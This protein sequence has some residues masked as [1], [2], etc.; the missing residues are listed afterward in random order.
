MGGQGEPSPPISLLCQNSALCPFNLQV[1]RPPVIPSSLS[2]TSLTSLYRGFRWLK[3][4]TLYGCTPREQPVAK[5]Q[6]VGHAVHFP[7]EFRGSGAI[8]PRCPNGHFWFSATSRVSLCDWSPGS[9]SSHQG[10]CHHCVSPSAPV[11]LVSVYTAVTQSR[12]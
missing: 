3:P 5:R 11:Q 6:T 2:V 4:V 12:A 8:I 7:G 10:T 1:G 9:R